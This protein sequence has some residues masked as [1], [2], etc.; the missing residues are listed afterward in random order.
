MKIKNELTQKQLQ[1]YPVQITMTRAKAK[2]CLLH[3]IKLPR[4]PR[5]IVGSISH[6]CNA[7]INEYLLKFVNKKYLDSI[8]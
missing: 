3:S 8:K 7:A 4:C 5:P 6:L 2:L 1:P